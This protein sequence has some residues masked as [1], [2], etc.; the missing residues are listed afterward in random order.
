[1]RCAGAPVHG[2]SEENGGFLPR[3]RAGEEIRRLLY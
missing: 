1:M 3:M 2:I